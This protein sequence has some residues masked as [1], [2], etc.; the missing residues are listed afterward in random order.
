[1]PEQAP[2][3]TSAVHPGQLQEPLCVRQSAQDVVVAVPV[4]D[5]G[6]PESLPLLEPEPLL[7]LAP[8]L[9]LELPEP[10]HVPPAHRIPALHVLPAQHAWPK[11]PQLPTAPS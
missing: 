11:S 3:W 4:Q 7:E 1:M 10:T 5:P 6:W 8:E 9:L 2:F